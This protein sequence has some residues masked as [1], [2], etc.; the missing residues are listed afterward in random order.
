M[1]I[2][3]MP[4]TMHGVIPAPAL[5]NTK[6]PRLYLIGEAERSTRRPA[7]ATDGRTSISVN[8][9]WQA[10]RGRTATFEQLLRIAFPDRDFTQ[11]GAATLTF[12]NGPTLRPVG[13]LTPGD[14][15][16]L[17]EG[18]LVNANVTNAS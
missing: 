13:S 1:P 11:P 7:I 8:G 6:P 14:V 5:P 15:I 3:T 12:R 16:E 9:R 18:L 4:A 17:N 10:L 2:Q